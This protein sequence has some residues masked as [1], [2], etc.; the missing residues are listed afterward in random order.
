MACS[1]VKTKFFSLVISVKICAACFLRLNIWCLDTGDQSPSKCIFLSILLWYLY[2]FLVRNSEMCVESA[3]K[4]EE[5]MKV[6]L[7]LK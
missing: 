2:Y 4:T 5:K 1:F 6:W 3:S 7:G